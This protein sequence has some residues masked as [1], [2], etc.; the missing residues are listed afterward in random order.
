[1]KQLAFLLILLVPVY[2]IA[3]QVTPLPQA[4]SP[5]DIVVYMPGVYD[6]DH[7]P[8]LAPKDAQCLVRMRDA[9]R[10]MNDLHVQYYSA[11]LPDKTVSF[12]RREGFVMG[13]WDRTIDECVRNK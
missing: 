10:Q 12:A 6:K 5:G 13:I 9:I 2:A 4:L 8:Q 11:G 3:E 7:P 1:M